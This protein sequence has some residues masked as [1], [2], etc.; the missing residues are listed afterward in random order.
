MVY[1][2]K[3]VIGMRGGKEP[4]PELS[5]DGNAFVAILVVGRLFS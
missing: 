3:N 5:Q 1:Y 2:M 4:I